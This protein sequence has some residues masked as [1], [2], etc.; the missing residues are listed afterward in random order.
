MQ[1]K[2]VCDNK[3]CRFG[4]DHP[5]EL[6]VSTESIMDEKNIATFFCPHCNEK[7]KCEDDSCLTAA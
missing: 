5:Y 3:S 1:V 2:Y 4:S 7:L 6:M